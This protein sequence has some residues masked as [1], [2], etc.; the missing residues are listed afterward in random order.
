MNGFASEKGLRMR[1]IERKIW[2]MVAV[3]AVSSLFFTQ[4]SYAAGA[5]ITNCTYCH[6]MPPLDG[7]RT[8]ATTLS[9]SNARFSGNHQTH[10]TN[11]VAT[12]AKCHRSAAV[13]A[14]YSTGHMD[15]FINM[16]GKINGSPAAGA[17]YRGLKFFNQTSI[18][19]LGTCASINCHFE[20]IT[21]TWGSPTLS[22]VSAATCGACHNSQTSS[23]DATGAHLRH[24]QTMGNSLV[25]AC[26]NCHLNHATS[27][28]PFAHATSAGKRGLIVALPTGS[29]GGT[30][31]YPAYLPSNAPPRNG[32]CSSVYCHSTVQGANGSGTPTYAAPTW[33]GGVLNCGSCHVDMSTSASATG[34]HRKHT[35]PSTYNLT[36]S[37]CHGTGYSAGTVT[38]ATHVNTAIEIALVPGSYNGGTAVGNGYSSCAN[39]Y[40]HSNGTLTPPTNTS[41]TWGTTAT[42]TSCHSSPAASG[43]HATHSSI[44][45]YTCDKCHYTAAASNTSIRFTGGATTHVNGTP[46]VVIALYTTA[47][48]ILRTTVWSSP[49]CVN[50]YCHGNGQGLLGNST[51]SPVNWTSG[52]GF[53]CSS[54]HS[55]PGISS[56]AHTV[57]L[58]VNGEC[59]TC[60]NATQPTTSPSIVQAY[61]ANQEITIQFGGA[62]LTTLNASGTY[63]GQP[64]GAGIAK[65]SVG[66]AVT[67][68]CSNLYCHSS[69][70]NPTSGLA[71]IVTAQIPSWGTTGTLACSGCHF[72]MRTAGG[73]QA[74]GLGSHYKHANASTYN[75]ACGTCHTGYTATT[76]NSAT[77]VNSSIEV[78]INAAFGGAFNGGTAV[79]N[80]Y[81]TCSNTY[82]HSDGTNTITPA[83]NTSLAWGSSN[84]FVCS[85]CHGFPPA[86][87]SGSPKANSHVQH[88]TTSGY[89]CDYC[90]VL[91]TSTNS[92]ISSYARHNNRYY[93]VSGSKSRLAVANFT[94]ASGAK[95]CSSSQCHTGT[96]TWGANTTAQTC[97]KCHGTLTTAASVTNAQMAPNTG[98]HQAHVRGTG[99]FNYTRILTCWEC[100][101]TGT[102]ANFGGHMNGT[103]DVTFANASTAADN[104]TTTN[105][106][107]TTKTCSVYC[108]GAN[109]LHGDTGGTARTPA[110][111]NTTL[112]TGNTTNDCRL[113]HGNPPTTGVSASTHTGLAATT[114]CNG[115]HDHF[116]TDGGFASDANRSLHINGIIEGGSCIGCH[117]TAKSSPI[118]QALDATV[119]TRP[120]VVGEF[121]NTW[122]HKRSFTGSPKVTDADCIVCHM[123]GDKATGNTTAAHKDGYVNLRDPDTGNNIRNVSFSGTGAGSYT[124]GGS[125]VQFVRFARDYRVQFERDPNWLVLAAVQQHHCLKCHDTNGASNANAQVP[126]T[127]TAL[128]PFGVTITGHAAP[129]DSNG[130][131]N[132]VDVNKSF[133]TSNSSYHPVRGKQNNWFAKYSAAGTAANMVSPWKGPFA[134]RGGTVNATA[135]GYL[136]SCWDCHAPAGTGNTAVVTR[137]VTA[138]GATATL[139]APIRAAGTTAA[140][141][142]CLNCHKLGYT[143]SSSHGTNTAFSTGNSNMNAST[144]SNCNYCHAYAPAGGTHRATSALRPLR[145]EDAHGFN[146]R[147]AGTVG[148]RWATSNTRPFGFIRNSLNPLIY[149]SVTASGDTIAGGTAGTCTG[150]AGTCGNDMG[151]DNYGGGTY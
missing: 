66:S 2:G 109:M 55:Y 101:T 107:N 39:T 94:F 53:V 81:S 57:H 148:S 92:S 23:G 45:P 118:A 24:Y 142:L 61:H 117:A 35:N 104:A 59:R 7:P 6:G 32:T 106:N 30:V 87:A 95:T 93:N 43:A 119:T 8:G 18:P 79:G 11:V 28:T 137:T 124:E 17:N 5:V 76:A 13:L 90:H 40:C 136:I 128:K 121:S 84:L 68:T 20:K 1:G 63:N 116:T 14:K 49:N 47:T 150:T 80:G 9:P 12:C 10:A 54:C 56:G 65:K 113:C 108:H 52:S 48:P 103:A 97:T 31:S 21:T 51:A 38:S 131:G 149:R 29:Y 82:C 146:D 22:G 67:S 70:Q 37:V 64:A 27:G 126:T 19:I 46:D 15:G 110:W 58:N 75:Y 16:T 4:T 74:S 83:A 96:M 85:P 98:G 115:C 44:Y 41:I 36:C 88:V 34:S 139:R 73:I 100:H 50:V 127:G 114:S 133:L 99:A 102:S 129:F 86:Y 135:Y 145:A 112:M 132:V 141:N 123:E 69:A 122:S 125:N 140:A 42:C 89:T 91:T 105:W 72:D 134:T 147:T 144:F 33:N 130:S 111:T 71:G 60:H 151:N 78:S 3:V 26:Q 62:T 120:A 143:A 138:H 25:T 77:H